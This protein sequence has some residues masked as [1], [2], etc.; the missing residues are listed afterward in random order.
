[1]MLSDKSKG[2]LEYETI[3]P[4][5]RE[6]E[7]NIRTVWPDISKTLKTTIQED[8]ALPDLMTNLEDCFPLWC[9]STK[10]TDF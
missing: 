2:T 9:G 10:M 4:K 3:G 5:L 6:G 8:K 1:M 7:V